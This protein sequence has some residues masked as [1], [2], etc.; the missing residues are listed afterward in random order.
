MSEKKN[1]NIQNFFQ[2][3]PPKRKIII[4][5]SHKL[6]PIQQKLVIHPKRNLRKSLMFSKK[7]VFDKFIIEKEKKNN[8]PENK[9]IEN[10]N[11]NENKNEIEKKKK[12]F[13]KKEDFP[14]DSRES[15]IFKKKIELE[16][17]IPNDDSIND[18]VNSPFNKIEGDYKEKNENINILKN[19]F[20]D[21]NDNKDTIGIFNP[22]KISKNNDQGKI[23]QNNPFLKILKDNPDNNEKNGKGYNPFTNVENIP[24]RNNPFVT[25]KYNPF[26]P[27]NNNNEEKIINP[28]ITTNNTKNNPFLKVNSSNPFFFDSNTLNNH[29]SLNENPKEKSD[30]EEDIKNIEEEVKIEKDETKFKN[31]KEVQYNKS[32]KFFET[33][34]QNLQFLEQENGKNKYTSKGSGIFSFQ[35]EK[36]EKG[37][38]VGI[39]TLRESSTKNIKI[40]GIVIDMTTVEKAKLKNGLEFIFIKNILV[41]YSK[42]DKDNIS[43]ET[44]ISFLRIRVKENDVDNFYNKTN[45]FFNL[46]KK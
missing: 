11:N 45:E 1:K 5:K 16:I 13:V 32:D 38:N 21:I 17:K 8:L 42:Y 33:E 35:L 40:Q 43:E 34:I 19:P 3:N 25:T 39:F 36:N 30:E 22:F 41:K 46:V 28:F 37:K 14:G 24:S 9:I 18:T 44:K 29:S 20:I 6:G 7:E 2:E 23:N 12:I 27:N 4:E 10:G 26:I 15:P 31:L